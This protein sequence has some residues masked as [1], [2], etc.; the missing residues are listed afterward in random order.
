M[1]RSIFIC[2]ILCRNRFSIIEVVCSTSQEICILFGFCCVLL[3]FCNGRFALQWR[4]NERGSVANHQRLHCLLNGRFRRRSKKHQS[5]ASV[6]FVRGIHRWPVNSPHKRPLTRKML[7]FDDVI[8][9][10]LPSGLHHWYQDNHTI[11]PPS[12]SDV[13]LKN[14]DGLCTS[15]RLSMVLETVDIMPIYITQFWI[16]HKQRREQKLNPSLAFVR[17]PVNSPHKWPVTRQMLPFDDVIMWNRRLLVH[18]LS[19]L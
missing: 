12:A 13:T 10:P 5:S 17:S 7:P 6:A 16:Q 15:L 18:G 2:H 19:T 8:M 4:H 1:L 3:W 9:Y 11:V 14:M